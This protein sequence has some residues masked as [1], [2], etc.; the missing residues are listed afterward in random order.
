MWKITLSQSPNLLLSSLYFLEKENLTVRHF[1]G[2]TELV[3]R[4]LKYGLVGRIKYNE[5]IVACREPS[6]GYGSE[7]LVTS[8]VTSRNS[9]RAPGSSVAT[10]SVTRRTGCCNG[11]RDTTPP[12]YTEEP[13][14]LSCPLQGSITRPTELS[15]IS[16]WSAVE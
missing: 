10:R 1:Q 4:A 12:T 8:A 6:L 2:S 11:T 5:H 3:H 13:C 9:G 14:F 15:S 7:E 16:E